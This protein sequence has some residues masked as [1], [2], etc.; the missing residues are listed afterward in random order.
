M[1]KLISI[2]TLFV[3][4]VVPSL[5]LAQPETLWTKTF[6]GSTTDQGWSIQ[7]T[8]DGGY[9]ITGMT[10]SFGNG[11][12][13]VWLIKTDS[14]GNEEWNQ[15]FGG[16]DHDQ[17][18]S[19]QQTTDGGFIITGFTYSFGNGDSDVWLIKTDLN[20]N[21]EWN[22]TF[23][24]SDTD[25]GRSVQQ[26]TDG[27]YIITGWTNSFGNGDYDVWLIK[28]DSDGN[29]EWNQTFGGSDHDEGH[30]A[31]QTND[32]GYI[33]TGYTYSFGNGD[34]DVW[35]IK[36]D[37]QGSEVWNLTFG[38]T[39][40]DHGWSVQQTTDGGYIITGS[41]SS[42]G[43]GS[44]DVWLIK[45]DSQGSEVWNSTFGGTNTDH[46][47]FVQQT[48]DGGYI[49]TGWTNSFG[50]GDYD[51]WLIKTDSQGSEVW[52]STF[53]GSEFDGGGEVQQTTDGGYIIAGSTYSFGNGYGDVWLIKTDSN[54]N[55]ETSTIVGLPKTYTLAQPYPNP[56]NPTTTIAFS[57]PQ[58]E[59][60]TVKVYNI[61]GNEITTLINDELSTGYHSI[62]W[63]GSHQPSGVYFVKIQSIGFVQT[64]KMVLLK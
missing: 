60:V 3:L 34:R 46:G 40:T 16:S 32:G 27:G 18:R 36:T 43:N 38:G 8:T 51:V 17:G 23:G 53:G 13:D 57:I 31:Q 11:D 22:Q 47:W 33:I 62:Q 9:I 6:G 37:L 24:G 39:N 50:N 25:L 21:E 35:L 14:D 58:T 30:S 54:G 12:Y 41:T 26:T 55:L 20:G 2:L 29:E 48:T 15:T 52:N 28:T 56:F 63:D 61:V 10:N 7:Q 59:F 1:K 4:M 19:V 64:R 42:F 49:I 5:T 45:T 44:Y